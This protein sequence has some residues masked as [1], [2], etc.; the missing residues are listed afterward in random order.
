M[1]S[2]STKYKLRVHTFAYNEKG[3][4]VAQDIQY[5]KN[6]ASI[7]NCNLNLEKGTYTL[8]AV[9]DVAE[10]DGNNVK[11]EFGNSLILKNFNYQNYRCRTVGW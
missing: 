5:L 7:A 8:V 4:L 10:I 11:T 9:T 1:E 3:L 6:Y 2:F